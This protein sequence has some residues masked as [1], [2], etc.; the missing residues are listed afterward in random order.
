[1]TD[2]L[3]K[4]TSINTK[5][6][7]VKS[8]TNKFFDLVVVFI[9]L[10]AIAVCLL[11]MLNVLAISLSSQRAV[12]NRLVYFLP[13]DFD[14]EPYRSV[15]RDSA[16]RRAL[17]MTTLLTVVS[18]AFSMIMTILCAYPLSQKKF[19]GRVLFSTLVILTMYF[20]AG[21]IPDYLNI[22]RLNLLD[23]FWV[24]VL[25][26][27]ISVFNMIILKSFFQNLPDSLKESAELDGASHWTVLT[28]IYLPLSTPA[29]AT[30]ALFYAVGR[31]N[32]FQDVRFYISS[33]NLYTI[34][35]RLYQ[36][37]Q[38]KTTMEA[39]LEGVPIQVAT[40]SLRAASIMFATVPI[41]L[42]YP[43]LQRYFVAGVT[44]GAVKG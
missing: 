30:I 20:S 40:E 8:K 43:W 29:L 35:F 44:L 4:K 2:M 11:P 15:F 10:L 32:G 5:S 42:V 24:L 12:T 33:P 31:W 18:T 19:V 25:P 17:G 23:T 37:I 36:I 13:V 1:M 9:C 26:G 28:R 21:I 22:K 3:N 34:Q 39:S 27:G 14:L 7:V 38:S 6:G 41:L 16:M